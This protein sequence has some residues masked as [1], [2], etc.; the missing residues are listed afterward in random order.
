MRLGEIDSRRFTGLA[1]CAALV[2]LPT[3]CASRPQPPAAVCRSDPRDL[4]LPLSA[5][6]TGSIVAVFTGV[7]YERSSAGSVV[8]EWLNLEATT[9]VPYRDVRVVPKTEVDFTSNTLV[10]VNG[11]PIPR[12]PRSGVPLLRLET[13]GGWPA[14]VDY[15]ERSPWPPK[16]DRVNIS[17]PESWIKATTG[18]M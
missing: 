9:T 16:A 17:V 5:E 1:V 11:R 6:S 15:S 18:S 13:L 10:L 2:V 14:R 12:S 7:G 3:A 8:R 4:A